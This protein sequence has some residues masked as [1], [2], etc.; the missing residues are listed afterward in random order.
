MRAGAPP[1]DYAGHSLR[2]GLITAASEGGGELPGGLQKHARHADPAST[3]GYI[4][5]ASVWR[6]N[7]TSGVFRE[8]AEEDGM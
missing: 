2:T 6:D 5:L 8:E 4:R 1:E 7:V 3:I